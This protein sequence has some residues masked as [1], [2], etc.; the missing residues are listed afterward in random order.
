MKLL[1]DT[2]III[3]AVSEPTRLARTVQQYML[4]AEAIYVSAASLWEMSIKIQLGKLHL[5]LSSFIL[6]IQNLGILSL[7][8]TWEHAQYT[9]KLPPLHKDP[10]DRLL[11]AQAMSEPLILLTN[12]KALIPY[13]ELVKHIDSL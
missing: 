1:L 12:D 8:I 2:H 10:F 4:N 9:E 6:E 3:W 13:H 5:N 7:P 11:I